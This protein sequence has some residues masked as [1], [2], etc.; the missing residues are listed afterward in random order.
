MLQVR[1]WTHETITCKSSV[2]PSFS[3]LCKPVALFLTLDQLKTMHINGLAQL[4]MDRQQLLRDPVPSKLN[5]SPDFSRTKLL[6]NLSNLP[7]YCPHLMSSLTM[8]CFPTQNCNATCLEISKFLHQ[9]LFY[10][11]NS[12]LRAEELELRR[13]VR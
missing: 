6:F 8:P 4:K 13:K 10:K 9:R 2:N 1:R 3:S 11:V 7:S 12:N 5:W